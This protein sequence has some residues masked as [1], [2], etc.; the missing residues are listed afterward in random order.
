[1]ELL[2]TTTGFL[3]VCISCLVFFSVWR[4]ISSN[5]KLPPGPIRLPIVGSAL[6][7]SIK[8]L[9]QTMEKLSEKYGPVFTIYMGTRRVVVLHGREAVKEALIDQGDEF[10]ARGVLPLF[11]KI[12]KGSGIVISNGEMWKQLR[13]F[14]L[15]TLRN[16]GMGKKSIE[17]RIQEEALFLVERIRSTHEK[18]FDPSSFLIHAVSNVICSV[19]FGD[20]FDYEDKKFLTLIDL[21]EENNKLQI[22]FWVQLYNFLPTVMNF[23]P[24]PHQRA[25]KN[26]EEIHNFILDRVK[27]HQLSLDPTCPRDFIDAFLI[28]MEQ[29]KENIDSKFNTETLVRSTVD[30][31]LAGTGTTSLTL[32]Y[33]LLTLLKYPEIE[34]KIHKEIDSVIGRSRQPCMADRGQMPYTDAVVHEIQRFMSLLPLNVPHAVTRDTR[35][36]QYIIPK[37]TIIIPDLRSILYDSKEFSNPREFNPGHFLDENGDFKK[38]DYFVPFSTGKRMC[39]GEGLARM[40]LFLFLTIILQNFTLKPIID[41]KDIDISPEVCSMVNMPRPYQLYFIPR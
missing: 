1:M 35:F 10:S 21:L 9:P 22:S 13:R 37:D 5:R 36:R 7:L 23:L 29:E 3:A 28:K 39:I 30:L 14:A 31:F 20:R 12:F 11:E 18:P 32:D 41:H 38:S 24:G 19:V 2:G 33:G 8:D 6:Q 16:F 15:T 40:E 17:E 25:F 4:M 34:E 27:I 26:L